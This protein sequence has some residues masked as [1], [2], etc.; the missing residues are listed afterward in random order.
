MKAPKVD[1]VWEVQDRLQGVNIRTFF[2]IFLFFLMS[3]TAVKENCKQRVT[4]YYKHT[5]SNSCFKILKKNT[6]VCSTVSL[7]PFNCP[8]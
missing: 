5:N 8:K 7:K 4:N 2:P 1:A 6:S 3:F